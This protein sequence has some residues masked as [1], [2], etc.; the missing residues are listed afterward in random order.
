MIWECKVKE[1]Q[2]DCIQSYCRSYK[3]LKVSFLGGA[4]NLTQV[5]A[6]LALLGGMATP[7]H[8]HSDISI[9]E[10]YAAQTSKTLHSILTTYPSST[11][12]KCIAASLDY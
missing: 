3:P 8:T 2:T 12:A 10:N 5:V 7:V 6:P 9:I 4:C 11:L 1:T